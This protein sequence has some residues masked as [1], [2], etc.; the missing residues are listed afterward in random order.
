MPNPMFAPP[1]PVAAAFTVGN[2]RTFLNWANYLH[3]RSTSDHLA[4]VMDI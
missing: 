2:R 4:L 1:L 3:I